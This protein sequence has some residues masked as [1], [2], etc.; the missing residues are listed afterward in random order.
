MLK[1]LTKLSGKL[2]RLFSV[3]KDKMLSNSTEEMVMTLMEVMERY[4]MLPD[5]LLMFYLL[6]QTNISLPMLVIVE[7]LYVAM[8]K[9]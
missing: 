5:A 7:V 2:T 9:L 3:L 1:L 4:Q 8:V 6:L